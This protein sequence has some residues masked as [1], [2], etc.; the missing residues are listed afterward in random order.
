MDCWCE[1]PM[2]LP[3]RRSG[4]RARLSP[5][6]GRLGEGL[7]GDTAQGRDDQVQRVDLR[8]DDGEPLLG[9]AP[10]RGDEPVWLGYGRLPRSLPGQQVPVRGQEHRAG[11]RG[12]A[13]EHQR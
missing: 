7:V 4:C 12:H 11:Q 10:G 8:A 1:E 2:K 9:G 6:G 5:A 3:I 13:V